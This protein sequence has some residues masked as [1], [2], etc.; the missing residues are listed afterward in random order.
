MKQTFNENASKKAAAGLAAV[1]VGFVAAL[2]WIIPW[3][4]IST[5]A[6]QGGISR[7]VHP[8]AGAGTTPPS[9]PMTKGETDLA[10]HLF[11]K[12]LDTSGLRIVFHDSSGNDP[13]GNRQVTVHGRDNFSSDYSRETNSGAYGAF[14]RRLTRLW[15]NRTGYAFTNSAFV[16]RTDERGYPLDASKWKF[17]D[18]TVEQ[19]ASIME[20]YA[21]R[22]FH[23][24]HRAVWA[25]KAYGANNCTA[26]E[27]LAYLVENQFPWLRKTRPVL[28]GERTRK[29]TPNETALVRSVFGIQVNTAAVTLHFD[30]RRCSR[31]K[32][33][34]IAATVPSPKAIHYWGRQ[35]W[36]ADYA[37][38]TNAFNFGTFAHEVTHV[39]QR[40][41]N[42]SRTNWRF[43]NKPDEYAYPLDSSQWKFSDYGVEQQ[44]SIVEDYVRCF[45]YPACSLRRALP[46]KE[47]LDTL[48]TLVENQ[49]PKARTT[50]IYYQQHKTL[51]VP[52]PYQQ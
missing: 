39:W 44:A 27:S 34:W 10:R 14:V 24:G 19:Q 43:V 6:F 8:G 1:L 51:P 48:A 28:S 13:D 30:E 7:P 31:T 42:F 4:A 38:E 47:N 15:Q 23:P 2:A 11:G 3:S 9:R 17:S 5:A 32:S 25:E 29:L 37:L 45:L 12:K 50:R 46:T 20:D 36:S 21:L 52:A 26:D 18:Y 22:F 16:S 41:K 49:F 40:Q 35:Y 33:A